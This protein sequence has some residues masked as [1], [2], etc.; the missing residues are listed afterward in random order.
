VPINT[1]HSKKFP[2]ADTAPAHSPSQQPGES[3]VIPPDVR[4]G[5]PAQSFPLSDAVKHEASKGKG[6]PQIQDELRWTRTER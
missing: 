6:V 4:I 1:G 5:T 3:S 2:I